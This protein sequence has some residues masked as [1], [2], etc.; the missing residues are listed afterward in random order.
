MSR[1]LSYV[2]LAGKDSEDKVVQVFEGTECRRMKFVE[3][4]LNRCFCWASQW[5]LHVLVDLRV[6]HP[7]GS[8]R[9]EE[10][11]HVESGS[12]AKLRI[13]LAGAVPGCHR[14]CGGMCNQHFGFGF[15]VFVHGRCVA[16]PNALAEWCRTLRFRMRAGGR[17]RQLQ[18]F[19]SVWC[20]T[21]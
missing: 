16:T 5:H 13:E 18:W 12:P 11:P 14:D 6:G 19:C 9:R 3:R 21:S 20:G 7:H 1:S 10:V 2:R 15:V 8:D 4:V 17:I